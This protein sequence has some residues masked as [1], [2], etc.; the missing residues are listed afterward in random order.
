MMGYGFEGITSAT[1]RN[2]VMERIVGHL[3]DDD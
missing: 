2:Q 3:L 1:S